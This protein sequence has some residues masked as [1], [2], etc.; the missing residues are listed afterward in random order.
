MNLAKLTNRI[1]LV[2]VALLVYWVFV[3][4][5]TQVFGFRV[6]KE[7][8]TQVFGMSIMGIFAVLFGAVILN[9]MYNLTSIADAKTGVTPQSK[10]IN[11]K[12]AST[13]IVLSF[14]AIFIALY[15]GD[16]TTSKRKESRLVT[17]AESLV[18]EQIDLIEKV[19]EYE[20]TEEYLST[21]KGSINLLSKIDESFPRVT[22]ILRGEI[23]G[24]KVLLG[25]SGHYYGK[26]EDK[27]PSDF[28]LSTS[29]EE[30]KYLYSVFDRA[31]SDHHFSSNNGRYEIYFPVQTAKG[32]VVLHLSEF[33]RYGKLGS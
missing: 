14:I 29:S 22:A 1:A 7:N 17:A 5:T 15:I 16:I 2:S 11:I 10:P 12:F 26:F 24:K 9:V 28:I 13:A 21:V 23:E 19:A 31:E 30:R 25:F 4:V 32:I 3:F 33:N 8:I 18:Q 20:F 6:F 27:S